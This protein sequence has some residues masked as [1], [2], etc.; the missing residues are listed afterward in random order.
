MTWTADQIETA[1]RTLIPGFDPWANADGFYFDRWAAQRVVDFAHEICTFTNSKWTGQKVVLQPWEVAFLG[2][3]FGWRSIADG[4]RRFRKALL[5]IAKKQGKTELAAIIANYLLFCDGEPAPEIVSAAGSSE[6]ATKIF[7]AAVAMIQAEPQLSTRAEIL[8]RSIRHLT[9][10]GTYKVLHSNS[11]T[12]HGGNLHGVLVDELFVVDAE[13]VDALET[14]TR[15]RSQPLLLFTTTAGDDPESIAAQVHQ[16]ACGVRD[17]LIADPTFLP[18][19]YEVPA[20]A[21]ISN[22]DNW[23]LAAPNLGVTVPVSE[24]E[25]DYREALQ[26]PRKMSIFRQFALNQWVHAAKAWLSLEQWQACGQPFKLEDFKGCKAALGVDLSSCVDTTAVVAAIE[27]DGKVYIWPE[28]FIPGD[29]TVA[30][31]LRRQK[32]DRAPYQLW[33]KQG[34]LTAT[35][36]NAVDYRAVEKRIKA[37]CDILDVVE[38]GADPAGQQMLLSN[39]IDAGLPVVTVR[40]GWSLSP[41]TKEVERMVITKELVHPLNPCFSWQVSC[42]A[43]KVD[44]QENNWVVKGRS[45]GRVDSVVSMNMAVNSLKFGKGKDASGCSNYY[46]KHPELITL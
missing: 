10:G 13:L 44:D 23:R 20:D 25:K 22:P 15:A 45:R 14:S 9:D 43:I 24:Y 7:K 35:D 5:F 30:G 1:C 38:I 28:I 40:Q 26:V 19:I 21:D 32:Q 17:G 39:L 46:E 2:N 29:N 36:G 27:K 8:S 34:Y 4:T 31:A 37:I 41:A 3:L 12:L 16:Y 6:Q 42:A 11:A 33:V 18:C